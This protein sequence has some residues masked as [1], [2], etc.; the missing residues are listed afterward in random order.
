MC[1]V[2]V[3]VR[4]NKKTEDNRR[5]QREREKSLL[6]YLSGV[7]RGQ[8]AIAGWVCGWNRVGLLLVLARTPI[9]R[10]VYEE[11]IDLRNTVVLND[12][13]TLRQR[14]VEPQRPWQTARTG[15]TRL[16]NWEGGRETRLSVSELVC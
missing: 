7:E 2:C 5:Q 8:R 6:P 10:P 15:F 1:V 11:Q 12:C 3:C 9:H 14:F 16:H 13:A 4:Y